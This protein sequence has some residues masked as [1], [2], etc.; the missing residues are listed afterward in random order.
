MKQSLIP[1]DRN[2]LLSV[3]RQDVLN[4]YQKFK[5]DP[6]QEENVRRTLYTLF[7]QPE[8]IHLFGWFINRRYVKLETPEF[9]KEILAVAADTSVKYAA[10]A[11][12]R[13]HAKS[14]TIDFTYALWSTC[15]IKHHFGV[16]ISDTVTQS[17]EFVN[18]LKEEMEN[19]VIITWLFGTVDVDAKVSKA[20]DDEWEDDWEEEAEAQDSITVT[21]LKG[22]DWRDGDFVTST[23]VRWVAKGAG[24]KIRGLRWREFRPDLMLIDDLE[25]D[26]RVA[27]PEQR[28]KLKNWFTKAALPALSR[29]GRVR[30]VG[31]ILH[32]DSLLANIIGAKDAFAAWVSFMYRAIMQDAEGK[33]YALWEEHIPLADLIRMRDDPTFPGYIGSLAFA[34]EYQNQPFDPD[35]AIIQPEWI[36]F[37]EPGK[38]PAE[39]YITASAIAVD[40]AASEKTTADPTAKIFGKLDV[41]GNLYVAAVGNKRMSPSKAA[42]DLKDWNEVFKPNRIGMEKG[43]LGLVF[44]D[45]LAGL[46]MIG[47]EPDKDKVRRLLAVSRFFEGGKIFIVKGIKNGQALY[48]QLIEFPSGSHD[49]MV[50][51]LV[52]LI[53]MLLVQGIATEEEVGTAGE[54]S[55]YRDED[56]DDEDE[57]DDDDDRY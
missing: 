34:Q 55:K 7:E 1:L 14:T 32:H 31:T 50:D 37:I 47:M 53:R 36:N 29:D 24:M 28:K 27:T 11:A 41:E 8:C 52:Y 42:K 21:S 54:Y 3:T 46:P 16:I 12:P 49:D 13:G 4:I 2:W 25:N 51:A 6:K 15:Y 23:G 48:D 26:E 35:D 43:T 5:D 39:A 19:N 22:D 45:L 9:H 20:D 40:P 30:M 18:A 10:F 57:D 33:D 38:V 17:I 56:D 44:R